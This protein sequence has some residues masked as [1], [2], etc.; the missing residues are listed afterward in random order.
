MDSGELEAQNELERGLNLRLGTK[1]ERG[2]NP[3]F[4]GWGKVRGTGGGGFPAPQ[5][6]GVAWLLQREAVCVV[7]ITAGYVDVDGEGGP[8]GSIGLVLGQGLLESLV[9]DR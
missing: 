1:V 2:L 7:G 4:E 6:G 9:T 3:R 8:D 5:C